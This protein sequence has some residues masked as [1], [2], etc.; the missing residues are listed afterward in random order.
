MRVTLSLSLSLS[1]SVSLSQF[2]SLAHF[3][4][5][6]NS[7]QAVKPFLSVAILKLNELDANNFYFRILDIAVAL[8]LSIHFLSCHL[9]S[10][11]F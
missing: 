6:L 8:S 2:R 10:E 3:F 11:S 1:V 9:C 4:V 5:S 7:R